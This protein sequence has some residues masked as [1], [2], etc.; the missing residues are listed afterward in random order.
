MLFYANIIVGPPILR[1]NF[2]VRIQEG[3][4]DVPIDLRQEPAAFPEPNF[5]WLI[6]GQPLIRQNGISTTY[7][8]I[9]FDSIVR[10]DS[11][12]YTVNATNFLLDNSNEPVG[13][14]VGSFYL[15][16]LCE[17]ICIGNY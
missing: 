4:L 15:D 13:N 2:L 14:D 12:N 5:E 11:G 6:G 17:W 1:D 3:D 7:S 9:T 16:V 8:S 10:T